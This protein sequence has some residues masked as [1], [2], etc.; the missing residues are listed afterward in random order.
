MDII[1]LLDKNRAIKSIAPENR[2]ESIESFR[3]KYNISKMGI[4]PDVIL[5]D[6]G[7][8]NCVDRTSDRCHIAIHEAS[9]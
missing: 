6:V 5:G 3:E 2:G 8:R 4:D 9:S 1:D 7:D